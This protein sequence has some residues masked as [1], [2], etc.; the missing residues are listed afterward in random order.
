[1]YKLLLLLKNQV[2]HILSYKK[3][4]NLPFSQSTIRNK[5]S[6]SQIPGLLKKAIESEMFSDYNMVI[7]MTKW[8]AR[9]KS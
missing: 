2:I 4:S 5:L 6:A 1:M 8:S 3:L 7:Y 9:W